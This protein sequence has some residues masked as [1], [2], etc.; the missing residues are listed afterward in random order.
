MEEHSITLV[1]L[2]ALQAFLGSPVILG[3]TAFAGY[4]L[5]KNKC[6]SY[7]R[8]GI[9]CAALITLAVP[10]AAMI[11]S[12]W[13]FRIDIMAVEFVNLP[14]AI[15]CSILTPFAVWLVSRKREHR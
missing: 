5:R 11:W 4:H 7:L 13:P 1:E 2:L 12:Y 15:A 9:A 8:V 3:A 14:A 6:A 10:V